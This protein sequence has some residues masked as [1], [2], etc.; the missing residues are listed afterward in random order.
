M[1]SDRE[2]SES[3]LSPAD[4]AAAGL[5]FRV[6]RIDVVWV[7]AVVLTL[8]MAIIPI[9]GLIS[10]PSG[11]GFWI[12][13]WV[14]LVWV[15]AVI[16]VVR[17]LVVA[18]IR[19]A[20]RHRRWAMAAENARASG[21]TFTIRPTE[22]YGTNLTFGLIGMHFQAASPSTM[23]RL[24]ALEVLEDAPWAIGTVRAVTLDR[25]GVT[26]TEH[27]FVACLER[28]GWTATLTMRPVDAPTVDARARIEQFA[29]EG[30][31]ARRRRR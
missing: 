6:G 17:P 7:G 10:M 24:Y 30:S 1:T 15:V 23:K 29:G 5:D 16:I 22:L 9:G 27:G 19:S 8:G 13:F 14:S 21:M 31:T 2:R 25:H 28:H 18:V 20:T 11:D 4:V 3:G 26:V 12:W